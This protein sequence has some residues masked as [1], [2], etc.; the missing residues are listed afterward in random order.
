[1]IFFYQGEE[2][3][4][5]MTTFPHPQISLCYRKLPKFTKCKLCINLEDV[6]FHKHLVHMPQYKKTHIVPVNNIK[7]NCSGFKKKL[8]GRSEILRLSAVLFCHDSELHPGK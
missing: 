7:I 1:M 3:R 8:R 2:T 6:I 5:D 4:I